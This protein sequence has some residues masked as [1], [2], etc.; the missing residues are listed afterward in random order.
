[1]IKENQKLLNQLN[2]LSDGVILFLMLP[3]AFW[4]RFFVLPGGQVSV[5]LGE[6]LVLDIFLT[7]AS[8]FTFAAFGLYHSFRR[9]RLRKELSR[10][11]AACALDIGLLLS[12]LFIAR[13]IHYSRLT[14][15]LYFILSLLVLSCKRIALRK[16][17]RHFRKLG[18]NRKHVLILG[19]GP[20]A[21]KYL[22]AIL[23]EPEFGFY[24]VGYVSGTPSDN[25]WNLAHL[26]RFEH[27]ESLINRHHPDEVISAVE[28][29]DYH[30][31]RDIIG[32]CEKTGT[33]LSIIP[34]YAEFMPP[35]PQFD[36]L[37]G[38]PLMNIRR[39]PLD[40]WGNAFIKRTVDI[41]GSALLLL[42][43]SPV[44]LICAIGVK[45]SSPGP[46]FF[47]QERVGLNKKSFYMYKFRSMRVNDS[48]N[49]AWSGNR[50]DR[51]T[52]FGAFLRKCSLDEIPQFFNVL[53]GD[54]SLIGPRPEIPFYVDQFKEEIP[55]YM[56]KHQVRPGI[57]GWAQV[58]G[59]R[60]DTSIKGRI[61]HDI[62]YIEHWSLLFDLKILLIT[63][64]GGKFLNS[65]K[66]S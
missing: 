25:D 27:L 42:I 56:V 41:I 32:A 62:Y 21:H 30:R 33:K 15:A 22:N 16:T 4:V 26:G 14:L 19:N 45:L 49:T 60:G 17:L 13:D 11:W 24:A 46:I 6:Y 47:K 43:S 5:Q 2:V 7:L 1:M 65:E 58:N 31:M 23:A 18:Y 54:M 50:D 53:K 12:Y 66:L 57:T 44:M 34:L 3:L 40:N 9:E 48:S 38:I 29:E 20:T 55:L 35:N 64:F 8:L 39:I 63:L 28:V 52:K 61:E 37:N 59:F 36:E 10:L 51:K